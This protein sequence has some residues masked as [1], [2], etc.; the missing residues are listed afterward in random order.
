MKYAYGIKIQGTEQSPTYYLCIHFD[1]ILLK[2]DFFH[3]HEND[4]NPKTNALLKN[5][6]DT[7]NVNPDFVRVSGSYIQ[8][9]VCPF[10]MAKTA[11]Y[12]VKKIQRRVAANESRQR[13]A[14]D[15][16]NRKVEA[17]NIPATEA[18]VNLFVEAA[19]ILPNQ[20]PIRLAAAVE[21][22]KMPPAEALV[23]LRRLAPQFKGNNADPIRLVAGY[24]TIRKLAAK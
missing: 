3:R 20:D 17:L 22:L 7:K 6:A 16:L 19:R 1:R 13:V 4:G 8:V 21:D 15:E 18:A 11:Q 9:E 10:N 24:N 14:V 12:L 2:G 23:V 5:I